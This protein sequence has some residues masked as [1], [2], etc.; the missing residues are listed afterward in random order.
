MIFAWRLCCWF[1]LLRSISEVRT[2]NK[3][4][5]ILHYNLANDIEKVHS[6]QLRRF[7]KRNIAPKYDT[8]KS[9]TYTRGQTNTSACFFDNS[10]VE[11]VFG[12]DSV[13]V[14]DLVVKQQGFGDITSFSGYVPEADKFD[15]QKYK[16]NQ[17]LY[18]RNTSQSEFNKLLK[19]M[20]VYGAG[21]ETPWV[22]NLNIKRKLFGYWIGRIK[23]GDKIVG[24]NSIVGIDTG[25]AANFGSEI[26]IQLINKY[27]GA[28]MPEITPEED[29]V[30]KI[31]IETRMSFVEQFPVSDF[32]PKMLRTVLGFL[33]EQYLEGAFDDLLVD[34]TAVN[35][36]VS[37]FE[38]LFMVNLSTLFDWGEKKLLEEEIDK[39]CEVIFMVVG[40]E[41]DHGSGNDDVVFVKE[42]R[43]VN[44]SILD[45]G[46]RG[47]GDDVMFIGEFGVCNIPILKGRLS[48]LGRLH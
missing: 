21:Y 12:V 17:G 40:M 41:E 29:G 43:S 4:G 35:E 27:I 39:V 8:S 5:E 37:E 45:G 38:S 47:S 20:V 14:G 26:D 23:I 48:K 46:D 19:A 31:F 2:H 11:A 10:C 24:E 30:N 36:T 6:V 18:D 22:N 28:I 1:I 42:K 32:K 25:S 13:Q 33:S 9:L 15:F 16:E 34:S 44:R 3:A 7:N